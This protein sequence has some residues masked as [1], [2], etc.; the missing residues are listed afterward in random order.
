MQS[1][2]TSLSLVGWPLVDD[3]SRGNALHRRDPPRHGHPDLHRGGEEFT[4]QAAPHRGARL[5]TE[6]RVRRE[7]FRRWKDAAR[8]AP[9]AREECRGL[10]GRA[11]KTAEG[12]DGG[13][14]VNAF[15]ST[16]SQMLVNDATFTL[17]P[18]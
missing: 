15:P 11:Q 17:T 13:F 10:A 8:G 16:C 7:D 1:A 3:Y 12:D 9:R 18:P 4:G 5:P 2:R 6:H 14:G